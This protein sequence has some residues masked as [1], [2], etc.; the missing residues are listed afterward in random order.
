MQNASR[1]KSTIKK[2]PVLS[3]VALSVGLRNIDARAVSVVM[4]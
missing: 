2:L 3:R 1:A 4:R